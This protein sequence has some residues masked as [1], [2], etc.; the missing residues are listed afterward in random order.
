MAIESLFLTDWDFD[1]SA[2]CKV[3]SCEPVASSDG[4]YLIRFKVKASD[5]GLVRTRGKSQWL[6]Y[7][8]IS[9][10]DTEEGFSSSN[11]ISAA[12]R[13]SRKTLKPLYEVKTHLVD[14]IAS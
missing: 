6:Y 3:I 5:L 12:R 1:F 8:T 10:I 2:R 11:W 4:D 7:D 13:I 9:S 14:I